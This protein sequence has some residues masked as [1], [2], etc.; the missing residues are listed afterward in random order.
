MSPARYRKFSEAATTRILGHKRNESIASGKSIAEDPLADFY[1]RYRK[2]MDESSQ[3][4]CSNYAKIMNMS[5]F[6]VTGTQRMADTG[7]SA[8][9]SDKSTVDCSNLEDASSKLAK[10]MQS[11]ALDAF[12]HW[13]ALKGTKPRIIAPLR[14]EVESSILKP[15]GLSWQ[16][17]EKGV[18]S[19]ALSTMLTAHKTAKIA[20]AAP[21]V[22]ETCN[23]ETATASSA[24]PLGKKPAADPIHE[25]SDDDAP[26][27]S[28]DDMPDV[29]E[30][31]NPAR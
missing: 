5:I 14:W 1:T 29:G 26:G 16:D 12:M 28:D 7:T 19:E 13:Q 30:M 20:A 23:S 18:A 22:P 24:T 4:S 3:I 21:S 11:V 9:K 27:E 8:D 25:C 15:C 2:L 6:T 10:E 17:A 31:E